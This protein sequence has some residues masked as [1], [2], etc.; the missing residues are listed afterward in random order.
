MVSLVTDGK[1]TDMIRSLRV[2]FLTVLL[3]SAFAQVP[4]SSSYV[5]FGG[6]AG[7]AILDGPWPAID[8]GLSLHANADIAFDIGVL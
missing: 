7:F 3:S 6:G 4:L 8:I 2:V 1:D 5:G